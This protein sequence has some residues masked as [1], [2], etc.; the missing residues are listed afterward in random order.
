MSDAKEFLPSTDPD[1]PHFLAG[2]VERYIDTNFRLLRHDIFGD[3]KRALAG[4]MHAATQD[5]TILENRRL[6]LGDMR[7][8]SYSKAHIANTT[9]NSRQ[10]LEVQVSFLQPQLDRMSLQ[11]RQ[12]WW[13]DCKRLEEGCLLSYI[14]MD[15]SV[16][17]HS[18]LAV[19]QK[20]TDPRKGCGLA[21]RG[22]FATITAKPVTKDSQSLW[23]L[24]RSGLNRRQGVLIEFPNIIPAT[25][26]PILENLQNM[27]RL[28][29]LKFQQY[30]LPDPHNGSPHQNVYQDVAPPL[31]ARSAGFSFPLAP[32]LTKQN[33]TLSITTLSSQDNTDLIQEVVSRTEL[34]VGQVKALI[35]ALTREFAFI[36]GPPGTGKSYLGLQVMKV[37][38]A[39]QEKANLGPV[40]VV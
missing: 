5:P 19:T 22:D 16:L 6:S 4:F 34:D 24:L 26:V 10:G 29:L 32:I 12:T 33:E 38:L 21:N 2:Q 15:G 35:A 37:L 11:Q 27:Q 7:I 36:Q 23:D 9:F 8:Y 3:L 20:N 18:F 13:E 30:I 31:Y 40:I 1:Q 14:W 25:F 28:S 39:I 17:Q